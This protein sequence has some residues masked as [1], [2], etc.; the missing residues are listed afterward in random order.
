MR[1]GYDKQKSPIFPNDVNPVFY[2]N[3]L[4]EK[5]DDISTNTYEGGNPFGSIL[6]CHRS[7][8]LENTH[9]INFTIK[10][11]DGD[12]IK[13]EDAKRIRKLLELTNE[14]Q[15]LYLI[16]DHQYVY[17]LGEVNWAQMQDEMVLRLSFRGL[18]KYDIS[19]VNLENK[20]KRHG[21]MISDGEGKIYQFNIRLD[22]K[23]LLSI[24][25]KNPKIGEDNFSVE[26]LRTLLHS[27]L[28]DNN[29]QESNSLRIRALEDIIQKARDQKHGTMVVIT[30]TDTANE[31]LKTLK[32]QSTLI[33]K[34]VINP[35]Y[36]KYLT[37]ID[38]AIYFDMNGV[39]YAVG[40]ILDGIARE[41]SGDASRG[42]RYN[43]AHR[44]H[45][46]LKKNQGKCVIAIISEDGMVDLVPELDNEEK[47]FDLVHEII[48]MVNE[49]AEGDAIEAKDREL[50]YYRSVEYDLFFK[51]A[52]AFYEKKIYDKALEYCLKGNDAAGE[53]FI[54][55]EHW[56]L[57]ARSN[58]L[59][60][61]EENTIQAISCFEMA[62][63]LAS[64]PSEKSEVLINIGYAKWYLGYRK[65]HEDEEETKRTLL[66]EA[67]DSINIMMDI[68]SKNSLRIN[69]YT[70]N[71]RGC[72]N[73]EL[74]RMERDLGKRNDYCMRALSDFSMAISLDSK[75]ERYYEN[76]AR[77]HDFLGDQKSSIRDFIKAEM[78]RSSGIYIDDINELLEQDKTI[79][80]PSIMYY[81]QNSESQET[82]PLKQL[83]DQYKQRMNE[84]NI[85]D[86]EV[87][88]TQE[89]K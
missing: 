32:R 87:A 66:E 62:F 22:A 59:L 42:A 5:I 80:A 71:L 33:E 21:K 65:N 35:E 18:S 13:L 57:Q 58:L 76:R 77:T 67:I 2:V 44:Y 26:K 14:T 64:T 12:W 8:I 79:W 30:D 17:G 56:W 50:E 86:D 19:L 63:K 47:I 51:I 55:Y 88:T 85:L 81:Q 41:N 75:I 31:E 23:C 53:Q 40:V 84:Q 16:A 73:D 74:S 7:S 15:D 29:S 54:S 11:I 70:F 37:S 52:S 45:E 34:R 1:D 69:D 83:L 6:F 43:S 28:F 25:F 24:A 36:I 89:K 38:G 48:D 72:C 46:K 61:G 4:Q 9:R 3:D 60:K 78:F 27:Q 20:T 39:C 10:F 82:T 68:R 49:D